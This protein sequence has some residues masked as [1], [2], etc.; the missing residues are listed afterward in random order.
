LAAYCLHEEGSGPIGDLL[1]EGVASVELVLK[2]ACNAILVSRRRGIIGEKQFGRSLDAA[3]LL[4]EQNIEMFPQGDLIREAMDIAGRGGLTAYD[5]IYLALA[6]R[7]DAPLLSVD[8]QQFREAKK[9]GLRVV[10]L[11]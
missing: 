1:K 2:E 10:D 8:S 9:I 3:I 7:L 6:K 5:S 4:A 11:H